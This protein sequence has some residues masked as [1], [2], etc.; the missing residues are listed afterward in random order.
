MYEMHP[1]LFLKTGCDNVLAPNSL[2]RINMFDMIWE[3]ILRASW[4]PLKGCL[5]APFIMKMIE[6]VTQTRFEKPVKHPRYVPYWVDSSNP[7]AR[8]K[9][10][11]AGSGGPASSDEPPPQPP[12]HDSSSPTADASRPMDHSGRGRGQG[13]GLGQGRRLFIRLAKSITG[14]FA[15]CCNRAIE[16]SMH[17]RRTEALHEDFC[18]YATSTGHPLPPGPPPPPTPTYP[19]NLNEWH[20]QEYGVPFITPEDE[21][22]EFEDSF[23]TLAPPPL[24]YSGQG[25]IP[26][27]P[28]P[29]GPGHFTP[30]PYP[31]QG[32]IPGDLRPSGS[33][34]HHPP[35]PHYQGLSSASGFPSGD[36]PP[37]DSSFA[38]DMMRTFL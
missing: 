20:Q 27:D 38:E 7:A 28:R 10:A 35:P 15:M 6:V 21:V 5:H 11:P 36:E 12:H 30:S 4:S 33:N 25:P 8:T 22:E 24:P 23:Y 13:Q 32:P 31:S 14:A 29:P 19:E 26:G 37:Q 17:R 34:Y 3:D 9:R 16:E 2:A 18:C 1:A